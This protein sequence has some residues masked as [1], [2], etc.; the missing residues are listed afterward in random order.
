M[1]E[2][3]LDPLTGEWV[4]IAGSRQGRPNR[5]ADVC[6]FCVGGLEAPEP[7]EVKAF[8]NRWPMFVPGPPLELVGEHV[9]GRGAAE[10]VLYS[11][12]H[13][14][15]LASLGRVGIRRVIDLWA[16]RTEALLARPEIEYALVFEK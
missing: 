10:V 13:D 12:D 6:P 14:A 4:A 9:A 16:E 3:R 8:E 5:P 2:F 7:Y 11:P 1:S 15:S